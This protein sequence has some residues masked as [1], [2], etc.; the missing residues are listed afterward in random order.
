M[1]AMKQRN[2]G[3]VLR[4]GRG[5]ARAPLGSMIGEGLSEEVIEEA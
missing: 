5:G 4:Y 2:W 3:H 1:S